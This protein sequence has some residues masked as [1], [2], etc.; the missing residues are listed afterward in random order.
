MKADEEMPARERRWRVAVV[1]RAL[2]VRAAESAE[3]RVRRAGMV[4]EERE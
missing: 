3:G 1:V 4:R 2:K